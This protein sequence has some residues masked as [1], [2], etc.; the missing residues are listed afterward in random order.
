VH[1]GPGFYDAFNA[2]HGHSDP[3]EIVTSPSETD[4]AVAACPSQR[5]RRV[6]VRRGGC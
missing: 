6:S 2:P 3:V 1:E 5:R 4:N